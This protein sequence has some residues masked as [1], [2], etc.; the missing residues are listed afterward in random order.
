MN[1]VKNDMEKR[2]IRYVLPGILTQLLMGFYSIADGFFVGRYAG[3]TGL[4]AINLSWPVAAIIQA[5]AVGIGTGGAVLVGTR[6]GEG[7]TEEALRVRGTTIC[8]FFL[9]GV[10]FTIC[11]TFA[12]PLLLNALGAA[13]AVRTTA[14]DYLKVIILGSAVTLFSEGLAPLLRNFGHAV[15]VMA[16]MC[17]GGIGNV[18]LNAFF[19]VFLN[20]GARGAAIA[21]IASQGVTLI[22][23]LVFLFADRRYPFTFKQMR[24]CAVYVKKIISVGV[25]PF[26]LFLAPSITLLFTNWRCLSYGGEVTL[27][28]YAVAAYVAGAVGALLSGV[29]EGVQP[30]V[31]YMEGSGDH[32]A[33]RRVFRRALRWSLTVS[34]TLCMAVIFMREEIGEIFG[35]SAETRTMLDSAMVYTALA[36]PLLGVCKLLSSYF[37]AGSAQRFSSLL[38]YIDPLMIAPLLLFLFPLF[39]G[40]TG[41]WLSYPV[42]YV[43]V[44]GLGLYF[45]RKYEEGR[46]K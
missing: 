4:A 9:A 10:F 40:A 13:D 5:C 32:M 16:V 22:C 37:Y 25:S 33:A 7:K 14:K 35:C 18:G 29:G 6:L 8:L 26:G 20:Y 21:T 12:L 2:F 45:Y 11:F 39:F 46:Y 38:I 30:L 1:L 31:S 27:A 41:I 19:I 36:F 17:I 34:A 43:L 42:T 44:G 3:D 23:F 28:A 15:G 24:P